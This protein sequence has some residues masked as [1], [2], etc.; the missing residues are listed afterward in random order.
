METAQQYQTM[1]EPSTPS[2]TRLTWLDR[3][4]LLFS[5]IRPGEAANTLILAVN[6]FLLLASYY[7]LK[8]IREAL[9]LGESGAEIK[10]YSAAGQALLLLLFIPLYGMLGSKVRRMRLILIANGFF[11]ACLVVFYLLGKAGVREGIAYYLWLGIYNNFVVAQ[12]WAFANDIHSEEEGKRLFPVIGIGMS[13]GAWVGAVAAGRLIEGVGLYEVMLVGGALL[14]V[15]TAMTFWSNHRA[16][17]KS[18]HQGTI[19]AKPLGAEGGFQL[20]FSQRYLMLIAILILLLNVTNSTG[21]FLLGKL[22]T[23]D[24][25]ALGTEAAK[26]A[27][28]GSFYSEF[29]GYVNLLGFLL[30]SFIASRAIKFLGVRGALFILPII[31]FGAYGLLLVYPALAVIRFAK[32]LE[33]A[34]DY[35]IM[36]TVRQALYLLTSR[37]AKYKAKAAIDTFVVRSGDMLQALVVLAGTKAGLALTGFAGVTLG[38]VVLWLTVAGLLFVEHQKLEAAARERGEIA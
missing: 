23:A 6:V 15:C 29:Y 1:T 27:F 19:A 16:V 9:I 28:I 13:L 37:E 4:F 7:L 36:N 24:A 2:S 21:E 38:I 10:S 25:A 22:V 18:R 5:D 3:V 11:I 8:T 32:I 14:G 30:Q 33:N 12:F 20:I 26:K 31:A 35:S 17:G 34:T